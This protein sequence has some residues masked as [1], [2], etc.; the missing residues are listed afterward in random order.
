MD[1]TLKYV[2]T[3]TAVLSIKDN[4]YEVEKTGVKGQQELLKPS[5]PT[6]ALESARTAH[7][8]LEGGLP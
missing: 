3:V 6:H 7:L 5:S 8:T 1:G 2:G 4:Y